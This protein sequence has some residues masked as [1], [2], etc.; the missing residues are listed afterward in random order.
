MVDPSVVPFGHS[1]LV[2]LTEKSK[3]CVLENLSKPTQSLILV[4]IAHETKRALVRDNVLSSGR[5]C[6]FRPLWFPACQLALLCVSFLS[7]KHA[8]RY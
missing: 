1:I 4:Y 5:F 7:H 8:N 3:F 2:H 6:V